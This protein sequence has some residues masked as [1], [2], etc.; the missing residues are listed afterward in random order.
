[1]TRA[2]MH[3]WMWGRTLIFFDG[4][5]VARRIAANL[6]QAN[7]GPQMANMSETGLTPILSAKELEEIGF[8]LTIWPSTTSARI[9]RAAGVGLPE[10][11]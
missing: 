3:S 8:K 5:Q 6:R 10:T 2:K 9:D 7:I 1:M 11:P 4:P